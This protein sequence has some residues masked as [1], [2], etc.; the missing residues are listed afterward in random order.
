MRHIKRR[1]HLKKNMLLQRG[2]RVES[3]KEKLE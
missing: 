1:Q 3:A 2:I